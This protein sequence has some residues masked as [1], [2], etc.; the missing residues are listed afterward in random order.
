MRY[1]RWTVL[2]LAGL[3]FVLPLGASIEFSLRDKGNGHSFSAWRQ[4]FDVPGFTDGLVTSLI[5]ALGTMILVLA[6]MIPTVAW[7]HLRLPRWR[8]TVETI[9]I[10][11]LVIPPVALAISITGTFGADGVVGKQTPWF[12]TPITLFGQQILPILLLEYVVLALPFTYRTLDAGMSSISAATLVEAARNLGASWPTTLL[13]VIVPNLRTPILSAA[14][15]GG[16][17]VLGEL[18]L[19]LLLFAPTFPVWTINAGAQADP[20]IGVAAS[21]LILLV[22]WILLMMMSLLGSHR[23]N[24]LARRAAR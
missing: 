11:P 12:F 2:G 6:L 3:F 16:A 10:L 19:A 9:C 18:T 23:P 17:M 4:M 22:S 21:M 5:L 14:I 7:L 8:R 15:L 20:K 13:R 1:A 24:K